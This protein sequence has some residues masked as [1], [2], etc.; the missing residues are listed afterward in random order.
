MSFIQT[1][2]SALQQR[3]KETICKMFKR[4]EGFIGREEMLK[5]MVKAVLRNKE[6]V[7]VM[8]EWGVAR[9]IAGPRHY[10]VPEEPTKTEMNGIYVVANRARL[11]GLLWGLWKTGQI[12]GYAV[13]FE[14]GV[15]DEHN[16]GNDASFTAEAFALMATG[17]K[18]RQLDEVL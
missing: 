11:R 1:Q 8:V 18:T 14:W 7:E 12:Y 17:A 10:V 13:D 5:E 6:A 9:D 4:L 2:D 15:D 3:V 16:A